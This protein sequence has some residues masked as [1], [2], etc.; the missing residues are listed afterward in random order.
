MFLAALAAGLHHGP[1]HGQDATSRQPA[2]TRALDEPTV[3]AV[4]TGQPPTI[5]GVLDEPFWHEIEPVTDF[6]QRVPVDGAPS[7]ELTELRVAFDDNNLYFAV[8]LHDSDPSGIRRSILHREGRIDQDDNIRIGLD[9]YHDRRNAYI[10]EI[11]PFGTQG[12]ALISDESMTLSNW[13]WE[14]VYE[15]EARITDEGWVVEAA[16]PF[17][18]I[19]F[20]DADALEMGIL[21]ERTIRR[22][23]EMVYFPHIGQEFSRALSQVSQYATLTGLEGLRRGRYMEVKPFAI[24]GRSA[25]GQ[26]GEVGGGT[27]T[28]NDLGLDFKYSITSNLTL[29]ATLNP[30]FAQVEADNVQINLTRFGL[31]FPEKR[32]FFLERAGLFDFG[33]SRETQVFF[34][35]RIGIT[36]DITGGTRL[37][38]QAGPISVGALSLFT[39]DARD[40]DGRVIAGGL[41]SVL[42]LR[43]DPFPRTT[44][45]GI[46]TSLDTDDGASRVVG[47]DMQFRFGGSTVRGWMAR[48]SESGSTSSESDGAS[49]GGATAGTFEVDLRNDLLSAGGSFAQVPVGFN[50]AL[51]FVRRRDIR[52]RSGSVAVFPRFEQSDWAR[53][54]ITVV[55]GDYISGMDGEKQSTFLLSH[56]ML[57]FDSGDRMM[58]NI[59]RRGEVLH[60]AVRIQGRELVPGDYVFSGAQVRF[61]TND[62]REFSARGGF[63]R[64][65]FWGGTGTEVAIGGMWKTGPYLTL[66]GDYTRNDISLP[67]EDGDFTTS[68]YSLT[69]LAAVSRS[70]FANALVQ[71]D[72]VSNQIQANIRINWIHTPGSDLFL[73]F[74]TGYLTG[75]LLD[76]RTE[77]W[78]RRTGVVKLTYMKAF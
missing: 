33:D 46:F 35:R 60:Q 23:N 56:N 37:T 43:A 6:R 36:N 72:D 66:S 77:R 25:T 31:F 18:T 34:S 70:L 12:D 41:N 58:L 32:E 16:I 3:R 78:Q 42:R 7:S 28:L 59:T 71:Y 73:V 48:S 8:V 67:V 54:L 47:G 19:R 40:A 45:G 4:R 49:T 74:D 29:D 22:K 26:Q 2:G 24:T 50:P 20:D 64:G 63:S 27:E 1:L 76:P 51:G 52:T 30:D 13:W 44:V 38:G 15:S 11:N 62:S 75:D 68:L 21:M 14:G 39:D 69:V 53:Q 65:G 5:D 57:T 9:T 55:S 61:N 10:F 17:T